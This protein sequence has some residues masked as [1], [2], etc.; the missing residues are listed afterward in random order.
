MEVDSHKDELKL[1]LVQRE[2]RLRLEG[3]T[4]GATD[5]FTCN[6]DLCAQI[7][8]SKKKKILPRFSTWLDLIFS[9]LFLTFSTRDST[10]LILVFAP[11]F[12]KRYFDP[13]K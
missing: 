13:E 3:N 9:D 1:N 8:K 5:E 12:R 6:C 2:H 10:E 11:G 4:S 7:Y